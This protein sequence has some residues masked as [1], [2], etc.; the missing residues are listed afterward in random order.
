MNGFTGLIAGR[1][2]CCTYARLLAY[3]P[4]TDNYH[5]SDCRTEEEDT[6]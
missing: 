5:C 2:D 4:S 6:K 3:Y 1:C